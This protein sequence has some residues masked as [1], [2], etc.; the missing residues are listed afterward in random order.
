MQT[1]I[2]APQKVE[3]YGPFPRECLEVKESPTA[4]WTLFYSDIDGF[5][6]QP[7]YEYVLKVNAQDIPIPLADQSSV[8]YTLNKIVSKTK[9]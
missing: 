5:N 6:Y 7:G 9:V 3:C 8:N 2:I 4:K 1:F